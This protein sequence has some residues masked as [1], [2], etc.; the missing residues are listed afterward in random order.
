MYMC[1]NLYACINKVYE[2]KKQRAL[3][4]RRRALHIRKRALYICKRALYIHKRAVFKS[5]CSSN[6]DVTRN[7][8]TW[9]A[10]Y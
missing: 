8:S 4:I 5:P 10:T 3:F 6:T 9:K 1:T 7:R 2:Q